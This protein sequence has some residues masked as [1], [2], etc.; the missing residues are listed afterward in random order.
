MQPTEASERLLDVTVQF[1]HFYVSGGCGIGP[2]AE[3]ERYKVPASR[4]CQQ[5]KEQIMAETKHIW[6]GT[7]CLHLWRHLQNS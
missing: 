1:A 7:P 2:L 4:T 6:D 5:L 3:A